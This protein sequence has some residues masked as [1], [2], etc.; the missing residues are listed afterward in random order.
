L[1]GAL[2]Q[3]RVRQVAR[4]VRVRMEERLDER[5]RIARDLHDTL[6]QSVQG[7]ILKFHA[8]VRQIPSN[9]PARETMEKALD[10]ADQVLAEGRDR[11]RDLRRT[12]VSPGDLPAAFQRVAEEIPQG[13]K[14]TLKTVVEGSVRELHPLVL[15]ESYCIGR[16]ALINALTHSSGRLVEVEI[17]YEPRQFRLRV[18]DDGHGIDPSILAEGGRADHWGMQGMRERAD[19]IGAEL[20]IW[21]G[22]QT[23]TEVELLVPGAT[24]YQTARAKSKRSWFRRVPGFGAAQE[25]IREQDRDKDD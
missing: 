17:A 19:R 4:Q 25:S 10:R 14:A 11:V 9:A 24:A 18:R 23:G 5:E 7:L 22:Q 21:S 15:E 3:L 13:R 2:Y 16:E 12:A 20:K 6:L 8:G 1:L